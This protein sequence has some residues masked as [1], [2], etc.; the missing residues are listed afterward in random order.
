MLKWS[1]N[2][3]RFGPSIESLPGP[4]QHDICRYLSGNGLKDE[5]QSAFCDD[6]PIAIVA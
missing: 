2:P 5:T 3:R 6:R 4:G 1:I